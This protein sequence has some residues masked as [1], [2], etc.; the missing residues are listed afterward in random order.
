MSGR[1]IIT[2]PLNAS[3]SGQVCGV[4]IDNGR[5]I[6]DSSTIDPKLKSNVVRALTQLANLNG[7][8]LLDPEVLLAV[9]PDPSNVEGALVQLVNL[10]TIYHLTPI[11]AVPGLEVDLPEQVAP[12]PIVEAVAPAEGKGRAYNKKL[13]E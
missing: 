12:T 3:Y 1:Y 9:H 8:G 11:G 5:G 7:V 4:R 10:G 6:L 2:T 13:P